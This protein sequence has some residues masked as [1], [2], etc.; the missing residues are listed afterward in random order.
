MFNIFSYL[1]ISLM[2][3]PVVVSCLSLALN[4]VSR[5]FYVLLS[6]LALGFFFLSNYFSR[7]AIF[8]RAVCRTTHRRSH[9]RKPRVD[10]EST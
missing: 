1:I 4:F 10:G 8:F 9:E 5:V 6:P 7:G 3:R 2:K